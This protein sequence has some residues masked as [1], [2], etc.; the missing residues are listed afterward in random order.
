MKPHLKGELVRYHNWVLGRVLEQSG[1][2]RGCG[3]ITS[4]NEFSVLSTGFP[5]LSKDMLTV[6][7]T[8]AQDD[9]EVFVCGRPSEM[10]A[11]ELMERIIAAVRAVNTMKDSTA[12]PTDSIPVTVVE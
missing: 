4:V 1:I 12:T 2:I 9:G 6:C 5:A 10:Q 8:D 7:G 3:K 11:I